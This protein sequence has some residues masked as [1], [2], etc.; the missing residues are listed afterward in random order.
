VNVREWL[1]DRDFGQYADSFTDNDVNE[2]ILRSLN[3]DDLKE[4]G[5]RSL[6]H[7]KRLLA[8]IAE[9]SSPGAATPRAESAAPIDYLPRYLAQRIMQSRYALEGERK[10]VTVLFSDIKGSMALVAGTDP[11]YAAQIIDPAVEAMMAAVHRYDGT[12]NRV[13]GDGIMAL[14]GAPIAQEDHAVRACYAALA[15]RSALV[16]LSDRTRRE[17]GVDLQVRIGLNSG[18]VVVRAIKN[19]LSINYDA[20]GETAHLAAR[21]EQLA[22]V[23]HIRITLATHNLVRDFVTAQELGGMPVKGMDAP[24]VVFDL[25]GASS[26]RTRIQASAAAGFSRFVGRDREMAHLDEMLDS[27]EQSGGQVVGVVGEPGVGKSRLFYE[28]VRSPR[29]EPWLVLACG[30]VSHGRATAYLPISD[31]MRDYFGVEYQEEPRRTHEKILGRLLTLDE[32][33]R[34]CLPALL[35]LLE[36]PIEDMIW[37]ALDPSERRQ[38]I[39]EAVCAVVLRESTVKPVL[40]LLEDLH[41][42]DSE[43]L[44]VVNA[45]IGGLGPARTLMLVNFRPEFNETWP[46]SAA[47]TRVRLEPLGSESAENLLNHLLGDSAELESLKAS[48]VAR[49]EGNPLFIEECVRSMIET[50]TIVGSPGNFRLAEPGAGNEIPASVQAVLAARLD[51]LEPDT[52]YRLQCAAVIGKNFPFNLLADLDEADAPVLEAELGTLKDAE[53][54]YEAKLFPEKEYT[55]KH[56]LTHEVAYASL[57]SQRRMSLH[58]KILALLESEAKDLSDLSNEQ[59]QEMT[60]H[61]LA[62]ELWEKTVHYGREAGLR[63]A[64]HNA[65]RPA[66]MAFEA[67]HDALGRLPYS[68]NR[69]EATID[70]DFRLRDA[71]FIL[72]DHDRIAPL[73]E[74]ATDLAERLGDSNRLAWSTLQQSGYEWQAGRLKGAVRAATRA[75]QAART[76]NDASLESLALYRMGLAHCALGDFREAVGVLEQALGWLGTDDGRSHFQLGGLPFCFA[77]SF[78]AW[79]LAELGRLDEALASGQAGYDHAE[80]QGQGYS[81]CVAA[82]GLSHAL[83]FLERGEECRTILER[84]YE[85]AQSG[86]SVVTV[87]WLG[88]K[89]ALIHAQAGRSDLARSVIEESRE[90]PG[91][92]HGFKDL[93]YARAWLVM[94]EPHET[95]VAL[96]AAEARASAQRERAVLAWCTWLRGQMDAD[97]GARDDATRAFDRARE[98]AQTL[99][100]EVLRRYCNTGLENVLAT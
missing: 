70:L 95:R 37:Q 31:L 49:T 9:L 77:C 63:L 85:L 34:H 4:L 68:V 18:E 72:G 28:F 100:L 99:G 36:V 17:I 67:A 7:R 76:E 61:A 1:K 6:G 57:V 87:P 21:M 97:A 19:D 47:Y 50:G 81:Q 32:E 14:F 55:F 66:A 13:Q 64:E 90:R 54:I 62:G 65:T 74:Q 75:L 52:K 27:T 89:L 69:A 11:D 44:A 53:F 3:D 78:L 16:S 20:M 10:Q 79:S 29:L 94:G 38:R 48:L 88:A 96:D 91:P 82:F 86:E 83:I 30:T 93:W 92:M 58:A 80:S 98:E 15:M 33:L 26:I 8:A 46:S 43:S 39:R 22:P 51:R 35:S 23:G 56:A 84:T 40:L 59:L 12:V 60:R 2:E 42:F 73:L 71:Y 25:T 41:W 5:V 45:L 24:V